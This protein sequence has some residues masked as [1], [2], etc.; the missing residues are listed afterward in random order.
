MC[1]SLCCTSQTYT[2]MYINY[3]SVK[4]GGKE[5]KKR[6]KQ[7]MVFT[8]SLNIDWEPLFL[9]T[10]RDFSQILGRLVWF[11]GWNCDTDGAE[12]LVAADKPVNR[13][14]GSPGKHESA[15][16]WHPWH[17][18]SRGNLTSSRSQHRASSKPSRCGEA[19]GRQLA[20][21]QGLGRASQ[22]V[23]TIPTQPHSTLPSRA[24]PTLSVLTTKG[25]I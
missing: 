22:G 20:C 17:W 18:G 6:N 4:Q 11:P 1:K 21:E 9:S 15:Q 14:S 16:S 10:L 19:G 23:P 25:G 7:K 3:I 12:C 8:P 5:W 2:V 24:G 13:V